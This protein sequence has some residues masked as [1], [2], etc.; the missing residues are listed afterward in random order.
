MPFTMDVDSPVALKRSSSAPMINE[1]NTTMTTASTTS[2]TRDSSPFNNFTSS[3]P[4]TRR[5]SASFSPGHSASASGP[6][7][8]PRVN[9]LRQEE[10]VDIA[11]REAA[12]ERETRFALQMS[13]SCEDLALIPGSPTQRKS[14]SS[15]NRRPGPG[16]YDQLHLNLP[17]CPPACTSPSPTPSPTRLTRQCFSPG[18]QMTWKSTLSPSPTRTFPRRSQSPIP[19]RPSTLGPVKRKCELE[20]DQYASPPA[21]RANCFIVDRGGLLMAHSNRNI[22]M[23]V[24]DCTNNNNGIG[25]M[26]H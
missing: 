14:D 1:L 26:A 9:Q 19:I 20:E 18:I 24:P 5:F 22:S 25:F 17:A 8:T 15:E 3:Q 13:Q 6:R 12:H 2:S 10:C 23:T 21:K 7:L 4:R 11:G 16:L